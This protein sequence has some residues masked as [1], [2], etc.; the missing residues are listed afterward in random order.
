MGEIDSDAID[1][2]YCSYILTS[3]KSIDNCIALVLLTDVQVLGRGLSTGVAKTKGRGRRD[4]P[5][6][7]TRDASL[8]NI[9]MHSTLLVD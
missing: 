8:N 4:V 2:N 6:L 1:M 5:A 9:A 7:N 3:G